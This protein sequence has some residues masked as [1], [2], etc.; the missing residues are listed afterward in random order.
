MQLTK[1]IFTKPL[2][3]FWSATKKSLFLVG[4]IVTALYFFFIFSLAKGKDLSTELSE[5][6]FIVN[7]AI[8]GNI[9]DSPPSPKGSLL[10]LLSNEPKKIHIERLIKVIDRVSADNRV[11]GLM[12]NWS[13]VTSSLS[14]QTR[15]N[16]AL[17]NLRAQR[18]EFPIYFYSN[19]VDR[20]ALL[21]SSSADRIAIPPVANILVTGPILQ[22][23]YFGEAAE[24]LG[25]GFTVFKT[26]PHKAVFEPYIRSS[27]SP[28]VLT[29]YQQISKDISSDV[30]QRIAEDR[31]LPINT[32]QTW[33]NQSLFTVQAAKESNIIT[34]VTYVNTLLDELKTAVNIN[35]DIVDA[36]TYF[37]SSSDIDTPNLAK[38]T[39]TKL[40]FIQAIGAISHQS[41]G[42][43]GD[44]KIYAQSMIEQ[45]EWAKNDPN[46]S[47]VV[48]RV[49]S[50]GG[51]A[52]ASE[53]IW[54]H[55]DELAKEKPLVISMGSAAAS[56]GYYLA[57]AGQKI[58]AESSTITGS[59]GVTAVL[60]EI[61]SLQEKIGVYFHTIS[62]SDRKRLLSIE[63]KPS[64][65]DVSLVNAGIQ[66]T[67]QT[68]LKRVSD[69]RGMSI[70]DVEKLAG[71]RV[72]TGSRAKELGLVD[73]IGD[74][75]T[76][77]NIAKELAGLNPEKLYSVQSYRRPR[78]NL[79]HCLLQEGLDNC[80]LHKQLQQALPQLSSFSPLIDV[81]ELIQPNGYG[82][83][84]LTY[85]PINTDL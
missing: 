33:F 6:G 49:N 80:V 57:A 84:K 62:D 68:F 34:D 7:M 22:L 53:L 65:L 41:N 9:V 46:I 26:G 32:V 35:D 44:Q 66:E 73:E 71:G 75:K 79:F 76:A 13:G 18:P 52:Q 85:L 17:K 47:A 63:S 77:F 61:E 27:P 37:H 82:P 55:L 1:R 78:Q 19:N 12:L 24:K 4:L 64:E 67:Y 43:K 45:I 28:E 2:K 30:I 29:E 10:G 70:D 60:P 72:Y 56:G 3:L 36:I 59:I 20:G 16:D 69:N 5:Q 74:I 31:K 42:T 23:T 39:K 11:K 51:S 40:G 15:L 48:L 81:I 25:I 58:V 14:H 21:L 8:S 38:D 54:H 50:P 83:Q